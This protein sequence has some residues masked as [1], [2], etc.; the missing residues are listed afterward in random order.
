VASFIQ[1]S[2]L[3]QRHATITLSSFFIKFLFSQHDSH[4]LT[5]IK[6]LTHV[7]HYLN[8]NFD[9]AENQIERIVFWKNNDSKTICLS[10]LTVA[11]VHI[12]S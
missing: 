1:V 2:R 3:W 10:T 11:S 7:K 4:Y 5:I 6:I 8:V 12:I 9:N